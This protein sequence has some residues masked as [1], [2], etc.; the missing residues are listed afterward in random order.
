MNNRTRKPTPKPSKPKM[1]GTGG[2]KRV[3]KKTH[4]PKPLK[5]SVKKGSRLSSMLVFAV[6]SGSAGLIGLFAW[7]SILFIFNPQK[8][9]WLNQVLPQWAK[10]SFNQ[11]E[12]PQTITQIKLDISKQ[13][14]IAGKILPLDGDKEK[15]FLL[16]IFQQR[17]NC[18]SDCKYVVELRVYQRSDNLDGQ[19]NAEKY[20]LATQLPINGPEE[21]FVIAPMVE[22]T[23]ENQGAS[24]SL[25][26]SEVKRFENGTPSSGVWFYCK[27]Q[28]QQGTSAIAYGH[29]LH[30][31]PDRS[32]LQLMLSWTSPNGQ[33]PKWQQVTNNNTKELIVDQT[34]GLEP[35][36]RIYQVKETKSFLDPIQLEEVILKPP[37]LKDSAYENALSIARSGLWTPA[38]EWLQFIKK[39]RQEKMPAAAQAQIDLI[40]LHSQLTKIQADKTWASP[41]QEVLADLIDGRWGKALQVFEASPQN[42]QEIAILLKAD[43][44]RLWN[45][46]EAALQVNSNRP[47]VQVWAALILASGQ[48]QNKANSWLKQA[49]ITPDNLT[50]IQTKLRQLNGEQALPQAAN[51]SKI[52]GSVQPINSVNSADWLQLGVVDSSYFASLDKQLYQVEVSAFNDGKHW[53]N[54]PFVDFKLPKISPEKFVWSTLGINSD[55]EIQIVVW[56]PNGEQ[57]TTTATIKGVQLR[58]G[59]L[60]LLAVGQAIGESSSNAMQPHPLA[61]TNSALEWVQPSP[62]TLEQLAQQDPTRFKTILPT[63]W[64]SLQQS[65]NLPSGGIP[66]LQQMRKKLG[67]WLIQ[68][69]DLTAN[70]KKETVLTISQDAIAALSGNKT[71]HKKYSRPRTLIFSDAGKIIY[72]DFGKNSQNILTAI[73]KL[74]NGASLSLLVENGDRYSLKRW[75]EIHQRF[76]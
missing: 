25:P 44:G 3:V 14:Q 51:V 48:G 50:Y 30:Y 66:N 55:P 33:L 58:S 61:L 40:R 36:L 62:I 20:Y 16:P 65:G 4:Q 15:S 9:N 43:E 12:N 19:Y 28:R 31:N 6:L 54:Y 22:A 68:E 70:N 38:F 72:T 74:S 2:M 59:V 53:L 49:K 37:A 32:N 1:Q 60:R 63:L 73:A 56:L 39:Q 75:S 69:I 76:E 52:I 47:E 17:A 27:G 21:S 41:S 26:L 35:Q 45:R 42:A 64:M 8:L 18:Q 7:I 10:I 34:V 29:V 71:Q 67:Y 13:K 57:Q 5:T 24:I 11:Q 23:S 46:T